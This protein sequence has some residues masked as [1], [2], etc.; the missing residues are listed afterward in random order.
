MPSLP[1]GP[2]RADRPRSRG[3]QAGRRR[4][5]PWPGTGG[6][7]PRPGRASLRAWSD[8]RTATWERQ[9]AN[10]AA[11][12]DL[13]H[14]L[15][16]RPAEQPIDADVARHPRRSQTGLARRAHHLHV[17]DRTR[18][19]D[20]AGEV[21]QH[22]GVHANVFEPDVG[23]PKRA[24]VVEHLETVGDRV[25]RPSQHEDEVHERSTFW[26]SEGEIVTQ[27]GTLLKLRL[28]SSM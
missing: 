17:A 14:L 24:D 4:R 13:E 11:G 7:R 20:P 22:V 26:S 8:A 12:E 16:L 23:K 25:V 19:L 18:R 21:G 3:K 10:R 2:V 27:Q 6:N 9:V 1:R 15:D 28:G 5:S